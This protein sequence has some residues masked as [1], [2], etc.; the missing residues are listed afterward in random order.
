MRKRR[1]FWVLGLIFGFVLLFY[2]ITILK[3]GL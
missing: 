3:M 2:L 1:N